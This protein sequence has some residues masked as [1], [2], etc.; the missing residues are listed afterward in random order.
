M[1]EP[2]MRLIYEK[3]DIRLLEV[4]KRN[5]EINYAVSG[6]CHTKYFED[7]DDALEYYNY[8]WLIKDEKYN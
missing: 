6:D 7:Y 1:N 3:H 4:T 8:C 5:G 2:N